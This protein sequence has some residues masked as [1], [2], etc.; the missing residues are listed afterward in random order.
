[1]KLPWSKPT[2]APLTGPEVAEKI[3]II[4]PPPAEGTVDTETLVEDVERGE[5]ADLDQ[6]EHRD[7]Q[8]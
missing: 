2:A 1:M 8:Q 7:G 3:G 4:L 6:A 5:N